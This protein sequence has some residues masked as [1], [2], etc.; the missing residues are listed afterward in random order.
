MT[1]VKPP[2][3]NVK[4][5]SQQIIEWYLK[6]GRQHLPWQ[7]EKTPYHVW[8]SEIMLQ[9]TQV[10]TVIP[11]FERFINTFPTINALANANIDDILHLWTGLG[12]YARARNLHKTAQL[13]RDHF[14]AEFPTNFNDVIAL[15]GIGRSTAGAILSLSQKQHYPILD[16]NVKRVLARHYHIQGWSGS[17]KVADIFWQYSTD[18]TPEKN[19]D[20]FNQAMMDIGA[21][22]CLRTNP[23]CTLCPIQSSCLS[24]KNEEWKAFPTPKPKRE[25][26]TKTGYFLIL[27]VN[28]YVWLEK[29]HERSVWQGLYAFPQFEQISQLTDFLEQYQLNS[30]HLVQD[31]AFIHTFSHYHL[32]IVPLIYPLSHSLN[33]DSDGIWFDITKWNTTK[34][35]LPT[36]MVSIIKRMASSLTS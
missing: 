9:Q 36:P 29:R 28:N 34:V 15:P 18:V 32:D 6:F 16:G 4:Q 19:V 22:L 2:S 35:G 10:A 33:I 7:I 12:Y 26:P 8:V 30:A 5:F 11:Y 14:N 24:S 17:K 27:N 23:K 31:N 3:I 13:I 1:D 20:K 21:M 25:K